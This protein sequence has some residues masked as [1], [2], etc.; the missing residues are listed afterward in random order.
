MDFFAKV[1]ALSTAG[2][3]QDHLR[4]IID[5]NPKIPDRTKAIL[6][7]GESPLPA[8][9]ITAKNLERAGVDFIVIPC[10]TAHY[11]YED[12]IKEVAVPVLHMIR[13][14]AN[15]VTT[16]LPE[17]KKVGLLATTGT[18]TSNLYQKD[19]QQKG[20]KVIAPDAQ[21]QAK[22]MY[23]ITKIKAGQKDIARK[24]LIEIGKLLI[25]S[26]VEAIILGCTDIPV[27]IKTTDFA[28]P[29]FD[30]NIVLAEAAVKFAT[31]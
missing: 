11:F 17:C 16:S 1:I 22:V 30:S 9:V 7:V 23:A 10:N 19:F 28:V 24:Q 21:D 13:E 27:V 15:A 26:K 31:S 2:S 20:I 4:I 3:D 18:I 12:L 29:V 5:N 6:T 25:E 8:L 14:V